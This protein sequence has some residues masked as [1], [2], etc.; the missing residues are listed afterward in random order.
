M[1]A[2]VL[3]EWSR[4]LITLIAFL[5]IFGTVITVIDGYSLANNEALRLLLDKK[6]AS[7]K[8][9][10]GWMTLTAVI[11]LVIVYLF[12][13]NVATMLRFAMIAS[14]ITTPFFAY[15]NFSLVNN[16]E[17]QVKPRLKRL[18]IIGLIYLFGFT[19]LFI[20]AWL[21]ANC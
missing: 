7:Q 9:L 6:E 21:T 18:S 8:V 19:L 13:G 17:H 4:F 3:G 1:Y 10:Y 14:F 12:A 11:G 2:S 15:L 16:K 5:C 20:I